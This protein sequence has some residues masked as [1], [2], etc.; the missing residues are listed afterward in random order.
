VGVGV[1]ARGGVVWEVRVW[2]YTTRWWDYWEFLISWLRGIET[3]L[4]CPGLFE[5]PADV[6]T[7]LARAGRLIGA[8]RNTKLHFSFLV[9]CHP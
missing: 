8:K 4:G 3:F 5:R 2:G 7:W 6:Y 9:D 1:E